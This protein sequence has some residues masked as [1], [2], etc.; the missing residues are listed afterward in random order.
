MYPLSTPVAI[1]TIQKLQN[2]ALQPMEISKR[3]NSVPVK[4]NCALF[5]F[6]LSIFVSGLFDD[7]VTISSLPT[8][9]AMATNFVTKL[10]TTWPPWEIIEPR[11]HL[12]PLYAAAGLY[13]VA[14]GQIQYLVPQ[15]VFLVIITAYTVY[16]LVQQEGENQAAMELRAPNGWSFH[17][18]LVSTPARR[19]AFESHRTA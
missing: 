2:F 18:L 9:V 6:I 17:F 5:A 13:S 3:Y 12:T 4:D 14:M 11:L 8:P 16:L 10:T 7:V 1:A 15:N 19:P